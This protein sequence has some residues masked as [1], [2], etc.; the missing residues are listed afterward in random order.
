M[1]LITYVRSEQP[2]CPSVRFSLLRSIDKRELVHLVAVLA[3]ESD[4]LPPGRGGRG[5]AVRRGLAG[6]GGAPHARSNLDVEVAGVFV[7]LTL[8][9]DRAGPEFVSLQGKRRGGAARAA[10]REGGAVGQRNADAVEAVG[11]ADSEGRGL[12]LGEGRQLGHVAEPVA[13]GAAPEVGLAEGG[14]RIVGEVGGDGVVVRKDVAVGLEELGALVVPVGGL[15]VDGGTGAVQNLV[16]RLTVVGCGRVVAQGLLRRHDAV[17]DQ[18]DPSV[19]QTILGT[20]HPDGVGRARV[21]AVGIAED[22][23]SVTNAVHV[24]VIGNLLQV[25]STSRQVVW[26]GTSICVEIVEV[27]VDALVHLDSHW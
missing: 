24:N 9:Q 15:Q 19:G 23:D 16:D 4:D 25:G 21:P 11:A 7:L 12:G 3:H 5:Q 17:A 18:L 27:Y 10:V 6:L 22:D 8:A 1:I 2:D 20:K 14:A 26:L 13:P